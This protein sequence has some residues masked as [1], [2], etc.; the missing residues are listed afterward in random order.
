MDCCTRWGVSFEMMIDA[1]SLNLVLRWQ[2]KEQTEGNAFSIWYQEK[3]P[4]WNTSR[5]LPLLKCCAITLCLFLSSHLNHNLSPSD[6][7]GFFHIKSLQ[8]KSIYLQFP[9]HPHTTL[10]IQEK[11][12][13][14]HDRKLYSQ[15]NCDTSR[16]I[17]C[18]FRSS[19]ES[20][21][22]KQIRRLAECVEYLGIS[23]ML[24]GCWSDIVRRWI[25]WQYK[26]DRWIMYLILY[27]QKSQLC[28]N[29]VCFRMLL[30][31]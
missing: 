30:W 29:W 4:T 6:R 25:H 7:R 16:G 23:R 2:E 24:R 14:G 31:Q 3:Y 22:P 21:Y 13:H 5:H 17:P 1:K 18:H 12:T 28:R 9:S 26:H 20:C 19:L 10:Y 15:S 8:F 27:L 11:T